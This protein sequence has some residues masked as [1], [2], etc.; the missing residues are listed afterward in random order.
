[1]VGLAGPLS[2]AVEVTGLRDWQAPDRTRLV[3]ELSAPGPYAAFSLSDPL[4]LVL[5][6]PAAKL[7][8]T[9]PTAGSMGPM[10]K[11]VR[12]GEPLDGVL[13]LV[14]DLGARVA[15]RVFTVAAVGGHGNRVVVDLYPREG[16]NSRASM[17]ELTDSSKDYIVVI[18]AGHG[19]EDQ[20]AVG[21]RGLREKD[22]VLN[23]ARR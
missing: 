23:V 22:V 4:R 20:G 13:R 11:A 5:D 14:L 12:S 6:L 9:L 17:A 21:Y 15:F 16:F 1:M 2:A 3:F 10:L 8:M 7:R 18:D 19:G